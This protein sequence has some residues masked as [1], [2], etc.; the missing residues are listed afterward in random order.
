YRIRI[1]G[2]D[3]IPEK[4]GA[5][6]ACNHMS[7]VDAMLLI[8]STDRFIRFLMFKDSYDHPLV[9]PFARILRVIPISSQLRPRD[10]IHSLR[11]ATQSI[12]GGEVVGIFPE[13]QMTR[14]GQMLPFRRGMERIMKGIDAPIIP[15][16]LDEV[17]GSI[18]SFERGR[19]LWKVPQRIPYPV[20]VSFG[21]PMPPTSTPMDVRMAVQELHTAAYRHHR[22]R[23]RPLHRG[24]LER[25]RRH[26][27]RFFVG[28]ARTPRMSFG[29][30]LTR[31]VFLARR[32]RKVWEGQEMVGVLLPPSVAAT[33]L[34]LAATFLGKVPVNLNYTASS[35][36]LASCARQCNIQTVIT[37][38]A[39]L[40]RVPL[41]VP[42]KTILLEEVAENPRFTEKVIAFF[43]AWTQPAA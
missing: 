41:E 4:G 23:M 1:V 42:G 9:K 11:E 5:L 14:I 27:F 17:W 25:A 39:F 38:K 43:L 32:L 40:E 31:T 6:F 2:R 35:E 30:A 26:P 3:N 15:V 24:F 22:E 21:K 28:D 33:L 19:F 13:G 8:A 37:S 7:M 12:L 36:I 20:T 10:L 16:H 18:F 29:A 34:N